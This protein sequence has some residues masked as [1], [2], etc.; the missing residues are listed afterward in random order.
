ML[1]IP[2]PLGRGLRPPAMDYPR[3]MAVSPPSPLAHISARRICLLLSVAVRFVGSL[4]RT[5]APLVNS[6]AVP[7]VRSAHSLARGS[8]RAASCLARKAASSARSLGRVFTALSC[9]CRCG[10]SRS[11]GPL[12]PVS[13]LLARPAL[14]VA[15]AFVLLFAQLTP[16]TAVA[17][18]EQDA[19]QAELGIDPKLGERVPLDITLVDE[20]GT[21]TALGDI[22]DGPM[23]LAL[24]YYECPSICNPLLGNI[25]EVLRKLDLKPVEEYVVVTVSFDHTEDYSL[26]AQKKKNYL[27]TLPPDFPERGWRFLTGDSTNID[28]LTKSVGFSFQ[29]VGEEFVHSIA[30]IALSPDGKIARY[31]Y[32]MNYLPFDF[33]M[34]MIEASKGKVGPS[35][36]RALLYCFSYDPEGRSYVFNITKVAGTVGLISVVAL[37]LALTIRGKAR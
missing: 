23:L 24:V 20:T 34:S 8:A 2:D 30:L 31:L 3:S 25:A 4:A 35:I 21:E 9:S 5:E 29:K 17:Q 32:G 28:R 7:T 6:L 22:A 19:G 37:F 36:N 14:S 26:A 13:I 18:T 16:A 1:T 27:A 11:A 12:S 10:A 33:K 15:V